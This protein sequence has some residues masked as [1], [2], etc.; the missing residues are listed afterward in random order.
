MFRESF[1]SQYIILWLGKF[2]YNAMPIVIS[3]FY[4]VINLYTV[5]PIVVKSVIVETIRQRRNSKTYLNDNFYLHGV[6]I[7]EWEEL[8]SISFLKLI[9]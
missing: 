2:R 9:T 4:T 3:D 7:N 1:L 6:I 8:E 5:R